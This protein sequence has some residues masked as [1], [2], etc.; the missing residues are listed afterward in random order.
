MNDEDICGLCDR[1][2]L[3]GCADGWASSGDASRGRCP[4]YAAHLRE[5]AVERCA[6]PD[7]YRLA[8]LDTFQTEGLRGGRQLAANLAACRAWLARFQPRCRGLLLAGPRGTGKT[9]LAAALLREVVESHGIAGRFEPWPDLLHAV[10]RS[11][12]RGEGGLTESELLRPAM[13]AG[14]LVLDDMVA[15]RQTE[16]ARDLLY[17]IVNAR[18]NKELPMILTTDQLSGEALEKHI[19]G[20]AF[21]RLHQCCER[22]FLTFERVADYRLTTV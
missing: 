3:D 20:R 16:W 14:L 21:S 22:P 4:N 18:Y 5:L 17:L 15:R 1:P 7:R 6:I 2:Y 19:G 11:I 9:H 12:D 10:Q 13:T 8:T